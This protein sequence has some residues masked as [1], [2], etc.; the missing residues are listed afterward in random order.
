LLFL[1]LAD[2]EFAEAVRFLEASGDYRRACDCYVKMGLSDAAVKC[3]LRSHR[4][5][6]LD[7]SFSALQRLT[8]QDHAY[9]KSLIPFQVQ[10]TPSMAAVMKDV[11]LELK[12]LHDPIADLASPRNAVEVLKSV[13]ESASTGVCHRL[14]LTLTRTVLHGIA[15][16]R[17]RQNRLPVSWPLLSVMLDELNVACRV[18]LR[19]LETTLPLVQ[20]GMSVSKADRQ[21]LDDCFDFFAVRCVQ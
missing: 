8:A 10:E 11:R 6:L 2:G 17:T 9:I 3:A 1:F 14:V 5:A 15:N 12:V 21:L 4:L 7:K 18:F 16:N 13:A 20:E 19:C